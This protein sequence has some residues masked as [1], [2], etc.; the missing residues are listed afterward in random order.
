MREAGVDASQVRLANSIPF[1]P[2]E[3][4]KE[5]TYCNRRP[6]MQGLRTYGR[7]VLADIASVR[8]KLIGALGKMR[9][10]TIRRCNDR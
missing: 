9:G 7:I 1:R 10:G 8:P 6:T 4:S 3:L 5:G 2:I